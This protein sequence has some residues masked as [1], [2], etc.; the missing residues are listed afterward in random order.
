MLLNNIN[1]A[2]K[3]IFKVAINGKSLKTFWPVLVINNKQIHIASRLII[4]PDQRTEH[5]RFHNIT[6]ALKYK[7]DFGDDFFLI[8]MSFRVF[9]RYKPLVTPLTRTDATI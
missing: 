2:A 4:T 8:H 3:H 1:L 6:V 7:A 5:L 9:T